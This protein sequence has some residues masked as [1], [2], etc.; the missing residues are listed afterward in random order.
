MAKL[1]LMLA[2]ASASSV[3]AQDVDSPYT[4]ER[5]GTRQFQSC[6]AA[7][8]TSISATIACYRAELQRQETLLA[9]AF[10]AERAEFEPA[11]RAQFQAAQTAWVNY[12]RQNCM[13]LRHGGS[14]AAELMYSSCMVRETITRRRQIVEQWDY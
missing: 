11:Q 12:R 4:A 8:G 13:V 3:S 9:T 1:L 10:N 7:A 5:A 2:L 14:D 6:A